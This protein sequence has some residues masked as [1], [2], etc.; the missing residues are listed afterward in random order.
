MQRQGPVAVHEEV[1]RLEEH[2]E[3]AGVV[4]HHLHHVGD[5]AIVHERNLVLGLDLDLHGGVKG[6]KRS[7]WKRSKVER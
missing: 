3:V 4:A 6:G 5:A 2:G 7:K 1:V